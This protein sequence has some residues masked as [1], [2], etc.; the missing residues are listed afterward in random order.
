MDRTLVN[1]TQRSPPPTTVNCE[2]PPLQVSPLYAV[3]IATLSRPASVTK[4]V[5]SVSSKGTD[6]DT[7]VSSAGAGAAM[8]V[9]SMVPKV[10]RRPKACIVD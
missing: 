3:T 7:R 6:V 8:A 5:S 1:G 9:A 4:S 10:I 2:L